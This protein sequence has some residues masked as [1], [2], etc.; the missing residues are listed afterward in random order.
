MWGKAGRLL[1]C[2]VPPAHAAASPG[3]AARE[4][5]RPAR[6]VGAGP[7]K[8]SRAIGR[9]FVCVCRFLAGWCSTQRHLQPDKVGGGTAGP[10]FHS[11]GVENC[12]SQTRHSPS[13]PGQ[14]AR[15]HQPQ[16]TAAAA[17]AT[18][19]TTTPEPTALEGNHK[20]PWRP[21]DLAQPYGPIR[22]ISHLG[23]PW[24]AARVASALN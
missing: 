9:A 19:A 15:Q 13:N 2:L 3:P 4:P 16:T 7:A 12:S 1:L 11:C 6:H 21:P 18:A 5:K 17:P 23:S 8:P 10:A 14:P 22:W 20:P 24:E